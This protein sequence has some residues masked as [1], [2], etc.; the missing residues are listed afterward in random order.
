MEE[1]IRTYDSQPGYENYDK[2]TYLN[3]MLYGIGVSMN[4]D[5]Y[6]YAGGFAKFKEALMRFLD[7]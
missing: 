5:Q 2:K 6:Q 7:A 1:Y 3:D 4:P